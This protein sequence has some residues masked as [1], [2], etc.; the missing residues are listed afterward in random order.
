[1]TIIGRVDSKQS[2]L[3]SPTNIQL[4]F[5]YFDCRLTEQRH[6]KTVRSI[7]YYKSEKNCLNHMHSTIHMNSRSS[8]VF[9]HRGSQKNDRI[10]NVFWCS[11]FSQRDMLE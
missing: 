6:K 3:S 4:I 10:C 9:T 8:N 1:M 11:H 5:I 2:P 7:F